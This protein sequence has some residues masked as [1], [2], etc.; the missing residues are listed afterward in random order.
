MKIDKDIS[1]IL[2]RMVELLRA[3]DATDWAE[4]L[5]KI[6]RELGTP[7][8]SREIQSL[9]GGAGSLNDLVLHKH[10]HPLASENDEFDVLRSTLYKLVTTP[11]ESTTCSAR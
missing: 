9:F 1:L 6:Q 8:V 10:G 2:M 11:G 7:G 5:L 4:R 3:G